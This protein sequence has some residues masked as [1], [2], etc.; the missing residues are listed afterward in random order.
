MITNEAQWKTYKQRNLRGGLKNKEKGNGKTQAAGFTRSFSPSSALTFGVTQPDPPRVL[1]KGSSSSLPPLQEE[2]LRV[3]TSWGDAAEW[4]PASAA[5]NSLHC[6]SAS[7][8]LLICQPRI[9]KTSKT[10]GSCSLH[11]HH[12]RCR[13]FAVCSLCPWNRRGLNS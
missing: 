11:H 6:S 2:R 5:D 13:V 9:N 10:P 4:P 12:R 8:R 1:T 3:E 7:L